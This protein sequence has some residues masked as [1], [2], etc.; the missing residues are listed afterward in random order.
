MSF[1]FERPVQRAVDALEEISKQGR[2]AWEHFWFKLKQSEE[3][4]EILSW[5]GDGPSE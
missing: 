5:L 1:D 4:D 3:Y 2:D